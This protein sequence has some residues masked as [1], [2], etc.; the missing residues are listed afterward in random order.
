MFTPFTSCLV[1]TDCAQ[2]LA[3][4]KPRGPEEQIAALQLRVFLA[5][6]KA[7]VHR[8][9]FMRCQARGREVA[10][11]MRLALVRAPLQ[12]PAG[13]DPMLPMR[14]FSE[15]AGDM[16]LFQDIRARHEA[17]LARHA[18]EREALDRER[19]N[20]RRRA[21]AAERRARALQ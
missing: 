21:A 7:H 14:D 16:E 6:M 2:L 8:L 10:L 12:L 13:F 19:L 20:A 9:M 17:L 5:Q 15:T 18:R 4:R 3:V 1:F 11:Y